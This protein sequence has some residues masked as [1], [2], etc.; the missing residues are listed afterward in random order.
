MP[1]SPSILLSEVDDGYYFSHPPSK[2]EE[3]EGVFSYRY[4]LSGV[5]T[6]LAAS[7]IFSPSAIGTD[8]R[9]PVWAGKF[10]PAS[11]TELGRL[12]HDLI[13]AAREKAG[14]RQSPPALRALIM[15]HAGYIYSGATA[16][17]AALA[18]PS[19]GF[20]RVL[21]LG[22][23][24]RVGFA[25][26]SLTRASRW[27]TPLGDVPV[28]DISRTI[29]QWPDLFATVATSDRQEHS[30]EV[31]LP[32][33]QARLSRFELIPMVLG[34]CEAEQMAREAL[35]L[36]RA[37]RSDD[38]TTIHLLAWQAVIKPAGHHLKADTNAFS[39]E[40]D[41]TPAKPPVSHGNNAYSRKGPSPEQASCYYSFTRLAATGSLTV[42]NRDYAV[43]G[44]A[45]M[46][47]EFSSAPLAPGISGWDW[48]SLQLNDQTEIMLYM[49][50]QA[51]GTMNPASSGTFV[52]ASGHTR[53]LALEEVTIQPLAR[54][55]SPH[56]R[57]RYPVKWRVIVAPLALD[58]TVE[59]SLRDQ[60]MRTPKSTNV[61]YWEGSVTASGTRSGGTVSG[62]GYV[63]LTGYAEPF[64][65]PM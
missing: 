24:H 46:D 41:L 60:E 51:D 3:A 10:Y 44:S 30:L 59:A 38:A 16:A 33:L 49:L 48:F 57:A 54:W 50:R 27:R 37:D 11:R 47:H 45:W 23:D 22:P 25:N 62:I 12:V 26:A 14:N 2:T 61:T 65:A 64:D 52:S 6:I 28:A 56:S 8:V 58:L 42:S 17:H 32:F 31:I 7:L 55:T 39:L 63:E 34:P 36:A 4:L 40:L 1:S 35:D 15:P 21:L 29:D 18:I 53:H 20:R 9:E 19:D 43:Q 5:V 13:A